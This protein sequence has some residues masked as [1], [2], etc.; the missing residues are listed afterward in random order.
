MKT[1]FAGWLF[2]L[3]IISASPLLGQHTSKADSLRKVLISAKPTEKN[4]SALRLVRELMP[5]SLSS[6]KTLL[7]MVRK[8][9][10]E[11][12]PDETAELNNLTGLYYWYNR[13]Y[14][15][16]L[17]QMKK[18][19]QMDT[20]AVPT[21]LRVEAFNNVGTLYSII[22]V[23]DSSINYA[24]TALKMD[25]QRGNLA[26]MAKSHYD[27]AYRYKNINKFELAARH[28][29]QSVKLHEELGNEKR[30]FGSLNVLAS[31]YNE[32]KDTANSIKTYYRA[33]KLANKLGDTAKLAMIHN[34]LSVVMLENGNPRN[35]LMNAM[36]A[37]ELL[38]KN[39]LDKTL[40]SAYLNAATASINLGFKSESKRNLDK[41]WKYSHLFNPVD[42]VNT[43]LMRA[44]ILFKLNQIDSADYY[45]KKSEAG[46]RQFDLDNFL[47]NV[48]YLR[49]SIDSLK[50]N[51]FDALKNYQLATILKNETLNN[52]HLSRIEELRLIYETEK[53]ESENRYLAVESKMKS[54]VIFNQR[55]VIFIIVLLLLL[56]VLFAWQ[57]NRMRRKVEH[58]NEVISITNTQLVEL[59]KTKDKFLS[60]I[61][62]DLKGPFN[63]L[64]GL[65]E[66][67]TTDFY[68][69][70]DAEKL[71]L[72]KSLEKTSSNTYALLVNL[73][74]WARAQRQGFSNK[75][76]E[77]EVKKLVEEVFL[78]LNTRASQKQHQLINAIPEEAICFIDRNI[79]M[80]VLIN[81]INNAIKFTPRGGTIALKWKTDLNGKGVI[82]VE[83]NGIGIPEDKIDHIFEL[84]NQLKRRG[85]EQE[86]GTG[87]GLLLVKEFLEVSGGNIH[88][89]SIEG[90]GS[91][92][93][94]ILP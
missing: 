8:A 90:K 45:A 24:L 34:N 77:V 71:E 37:I 5:D 2:T 87:L 64:L 27:L 63:S 33:I 7:D 6:A 92:F 78:I 80:S 13:N 12:K 9:E 42:M 44:N 20:N 35:A 50:G 16:A 1:S 55:I 40:P 28:G 11:L 29:I 31:L 84:D 91:T 10:N 17:L 36:R 51:Y 67:L 86:S 66:N 41:A 76:V 15:S 38:Q 4:S 48:L 21:G 89:Q 72:L 14:D 54:D 46:A 68:N 53:K 60:I 57:L 58:Q 79:L 52:S 59:N 85:T 22:G 74:D 94:V 26:G 19:T 3:L 81:L 18:T 70:T 93:C 39:E 56:L 49:A 75:P 25:E 30:L 61:A 88:V 32:I 23:L 69:F 43:Y 47:S 82:C 62:H 73:L 65:L 83:D